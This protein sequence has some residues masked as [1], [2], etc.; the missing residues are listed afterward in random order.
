MLAAGS[1]WV[2]P[3]SSWDQVCRHDAAA[4]NAGGCGHRNGN[5]GDVGLLHHCAGITRED[6]I[7]HVL[8]DNVPIRNTILPMR[9]ARDALMMTFGNGEG[10]AG[11][12]AD[13]IPALAGG[14]RP[15][16]PRF[17]IT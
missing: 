11:P 9:T 15:S 8:M 14:R 16:P 17:S 1:F 4:R 12:R 5:R 3:R 10:A 13:L 6:S 2:V 7:L